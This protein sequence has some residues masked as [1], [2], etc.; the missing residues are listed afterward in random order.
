MPL[1]V[2]KVSRGIWK[3]LRKDFA[4]V[5]KGSECTDISCDSWRVWNFSNC[6]GSMD[7]KY[8]QIKAPPNAGSDYFDYKGNHSIVLVCD[9]KY[10]FT[11]VD[12]GA[13][14]RESDGG[15]SRKVNLVHDLG[16]GPCIFH[17]LP[18]CLA[19]TAQ[20][21]MCSWEMQHSH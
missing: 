14:G 10:C 2:S 9:A 15:I 12:I 13:Y 7:R 5:P 3:A 19:A 16:R 4:F 1:I 8:M 17:H 6:V 21:H 18:S 20:H 11:M